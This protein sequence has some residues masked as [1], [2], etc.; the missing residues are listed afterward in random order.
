MSSIFYHG[1]FYALQYYR[2]E[3]HYNHGLFQ[4]KPEKRFTKLPLAT[5][6]VVFENLKL[7]DPANDGPVVLAFQDPSAGFISKVRI[8]EDVRLHYQAFN[9]KSLTLNGPANLGLDA[10][11]GIVSLSLSNQKLLS[12][13]EIKSL[14]EKE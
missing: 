13:D 10:N 3:E 2:I 8:N 11:G 1:D 4:L 14:C 5:G 6:Q 12:P 7:S 9:C